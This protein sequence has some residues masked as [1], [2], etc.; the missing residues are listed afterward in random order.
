[1]DFRRYNMRDIPEL[2]NPVW[3]GH[4]TRGTIPEKPLSDPPHHPLSVVDALHESERDVDERSDVV[5]HRAFRCLGYETVSFKH[6]GVHYFL[7]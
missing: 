2:T 3:K 1:M 5:L 6:H 4:Q 7:K